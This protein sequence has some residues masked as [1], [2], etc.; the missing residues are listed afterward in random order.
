MVRAPSSPP[1]LFSLHPAVRLTFLA[2]PHQNDHERK[3]RLYDAD[4]TSD[5]RLLA[6]SLPASDLA[7]ATI[8][9]LLRNESSA[10]CRIPLYYELKLCAILWLIAPQTRGAQVLYKEVVHPLL[11][12][13]AS[14]FDPTFSSDG[15]VRETCASA[16]QPVCSPQKKPHLCN[17]H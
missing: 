15:K 9:Q 16:I 11:H 5:L 4:C 3:R 6:C 10:A 13:Y 12:K 17:G 2:D 14:Q 7:G 8:T 1:A